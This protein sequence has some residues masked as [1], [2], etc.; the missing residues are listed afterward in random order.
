MSKSNDLER[1]FGVER[2]SFYLREAGGDIEL[3]IELYDWGIQMS[4]A[5][6]AHLAYVEVAVR[7]A[8][9]MQLRTYNADQSLPNGTQFTEKWALDRNTASIIYGIIGEKLG[10]ARKDAK[11]AS[12]A[13]GEGHPRYGDLVTHTD[14]ISQLTF[15]P[16]VRLV[17][18]ADSRRNQPYQNRLWQECLHKAF[19]G[20]YGT[21]SGRR[22]IGGRLETLRVLRNR[23]AHHENILYVEHLDRLKDSLII[24]RAIDPDLPNLVMRSNQIRSL[25]KQDPRLR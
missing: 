10:T 11:V 4:A 9:D 20:A 19:P 3:A 22:F 24:L 6:H 25:L 14:I 13:R 21:E 12:K 1:F 23:I 18:L 7:N 17:S 8:I 2:A 16:W 15:G 5:W